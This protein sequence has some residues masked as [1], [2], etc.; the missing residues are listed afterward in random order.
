MSKMVMCLLIAKA[1][2]LTAAFI[3]AF[4]VS[5]AQAQISMQLVPISMACGPHADLLE[6]IKND[7]K[8][9]LLGRGLARGEGLAELFVSTEGGWSFILTPSPD[10]PT[11][12]LV[13][14]NHWQILNA[15]DEEAKESAEW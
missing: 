5:M 12:V 10:Q 4:F 9:R 14:G 8:E 15:P 6:V 11:C 3:A 1:L 13:G 2:L 7:H